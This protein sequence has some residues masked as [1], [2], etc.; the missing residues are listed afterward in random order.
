[1]KKTAESVNIL[2]SKGET[3]VNSGKMTLGTSRDFNSN[4]KNIVA[5]SAYTQGNVVDSQFDLNSNGPLLYEW[6]EQDRLRTIARFYSIF[7]TYPTLVDYPYLTESDV[8][9]ASGALDNSQ[10]FPIFKVPGKGKG[11]VEWFLSAP[12]YNGDESEGN[13]VENVEF[14]EALGLSPEPK[15]RVVNQ[16]WFPFSGKNYSGTL[17]QLYVDS[18]DGNRMKV[19]PYQM[20]RGIPQYVSGNPYFSGNPYGVPR[21]PDSGN[22]ILP[23]LSMGAV[24]GNNNAGIGVILDTERNPGL[25]D[26]KV[27]RYTEP[28]TV[29]NVDWENHSSPF[30]VGPNTVSGLSEL[31]SSGTTWAP[32][33]LNYAYNDGDP[34]PIL[35]QG[36]TTLRIGAAYNIGMQAYFEPEIESGDDPLG[37]DAAKYVSVPIVP[38]FRGESLKIG[39]YVYA[40]VMG[41]VLTYEQEGL[42]PYPPAVQYD[43]GTSTTR[44]ARL[45]NPWY[46]WYD[47]TGGATGWTGTPQFQ[48]A[49][50]PDEGV[51]I[52]E[53]KNGQTLPYL[54][55]A[56]QGSVIVHPVST[57]NPADS[58]N[59]SGRMTLIGPAEYEQANSGSNP[60]AN[61]VFTYLTKFPGAPERAQPVGTALECVDGT[62]QWTYT[63]GALLPNN[64]Q[65]VS[66]VGSGYDSD[67]F[68]VETFNETKNDLVIEL[69]IVDGALSGTPSAVGSGS[70]VS[71]YDNY[72]KGT[73]FT[74]LA[75]SVSGATVDQNPNGEPMI[76]VVDTNDGATVITFS[77][78]SAGSGYKDTTTATLFVTRRLGIVAPKVDIVL[79]GSG[80][81]S[82]VS[83]RDVGYGNETG[84][85]V[86]VLPYVNAG[87]FTLDID[88]DTTNAKAVKGGFNYAV[89]SS[90]ESTVLRAI[91][92]TVVDYTINIEQVNGLVPNSQS[93]VS[94]QYSVSVL[95]TNTF[96]LPIIETGQ[97]LT[98]SENIVRNNVTTAQ[99][100]SGGPVVAPVGGWDSYVYANTATFLQKAGKNELTS[101]GGTYTIGDTTAGNG[102][103]T[104][105]L[106][107]YSVDTTS[108][109][110]VTSVS[111]YGPADDGYPFN[112]VYTVAGGGSN[113]TIELKSWTS[114]TKPSP[115]KGQAGFL[116]SQG[117][118]YSTASGVSTFNL[119]ANPLFVFGEVDNPGAGNCTIFEY[120]PASGL[121]EIAMP[122]R[123][124]G[125]VYIDLSRY[126]VGDSIEFYQGTADTGEFDIDSIDVAQSIL[127]LTQTDFGTS[128][129]VPPNSDYAWFPTRNLTET[130]TTVDLVA[131]VDGQVTSITIATTGNRLRYGDYLLVLAGDQNL[132]FQFVPTMDVPP[133]L[134]PYVNNRAATADEW[135]AYRTIMKS[136]VNLLNVPLILNFN[137]M[138]PNY[139][140]NSWYWFGDGGKDVIGT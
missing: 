9:D 97:I 63:G 30:V 31:N 11:K 75:E 53:T 101:G 79:D 133:Q 70:T 130:A 127:T 82:S 121:G 54:S 60:N 71:D 18:A 13:L 67:A 139:F 135:N 110:T 91:S 102:S 35:V 23:Q 10:E 16:F 2:Y 47:V 134:Q 24:P 7:E 62:G 115:N 80:G 128:F 46:D 65:T 1:M 84:D 106:T 66:A 136:A 73:T 58:E 83:V 99:A 109:N 12:V 72:P 8:W 68:N 34:I 140:N 36:Q 131:N 26:V 48:V 20:G 4:L 32:W 21:W 19:V 15:S 25:E 81:L 17:V 76:I 95:E 57:V 122:V 123:E 126:M 56:N 116:T 112:T 50:I 64:T 78:I 107:I 55:Q 28:G 74:I 105:D 14:Y 33:S 6:M 103:E 22:P 114:S 61:C 94:P 118:G 138:Y 88:I 119:S 86:R 41:H 108:S 92:N 38:L 42:S 59:G 132:V 37:V 44:D 125:S 89:E 113:A 137:P 98:L 51:A 27:Y 117:T 77:V 49:G 93:M 85:T 100:S 29:R 90:V 39:S 69:E 120:N 87:K 40:S 52:I 5:G 124:D 45:E 96:T 104:F 43:L 129:V 3:I 111:Y